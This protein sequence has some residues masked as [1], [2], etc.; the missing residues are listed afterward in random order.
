MGD[1]SEVAS[2]RSLTAMA[3]LAGVQGQSPSRMMNLF[4][5]HFLV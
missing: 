3:V 5:V 2:K 1:I 4:F